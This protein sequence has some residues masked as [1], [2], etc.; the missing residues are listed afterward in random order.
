[1]S[2]QIINA[3]ALDGLR[4]LPDESVQCVVTSPPYWGLRSY[5][6]ETGMIGLEPTLEEHLHNLVEVFREV[7]R[8]LRRDG[9]LWLNYGD[10]YAGSGKGGGTKSKQGTHP[11]SFTEAKDINAPFRAGFKPK[12]LMMLP[13]RVAMALQA[14]GV[15]D[16]SALH[17]LGHVWDELLDAYRDDVIPDKV[18]AVLDE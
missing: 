8:V 11:G 6:G 1:M 4:S 10:A 13:A 5:M 17:T 9:T 7:W 12:D 18:R 14:D 3:H 16:F 15:A 2:V